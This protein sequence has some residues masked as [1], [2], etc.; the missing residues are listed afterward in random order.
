MQFE[1]QRHPPEVGRKKKFVRK[2]IWKRSVKV[3]LR[4]AV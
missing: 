1:Y 3:L 4:G 2:K